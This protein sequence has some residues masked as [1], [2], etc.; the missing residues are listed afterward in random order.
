MTHT[1]PRR[2]FDQWMAVN[3]DY[4]DDYERWDG[5]G[6]DYGAF[7][8]PKIVRPPSPSLPPAQHPTGAVGFFVQGGKPDEF[9]LYPAFK[10]GGYTPSRGQKAA[11][12]LFAGMH[13][14][15]F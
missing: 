11:L 3:R 7:G 14:R 2:A 12:D 10:L 13:V 15:G 4:I 5:D 6:F 9:A 8:P 1:T